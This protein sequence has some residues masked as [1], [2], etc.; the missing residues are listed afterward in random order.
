[1]LV[2]SILVTCK[3]V[4]TSFKEV[5]RGFFNSQP[6]V[7]AFWNSLQRQ[8]EWTRT[9]KVLLA[10]FVTL[11]YWNVSTMYYYFIVWILKNGVVSSWEEA[12]SL[13]VLSTHI[14]RHHL[15]SELIIRAFN[16]WSVFYWFEYKPTNTI[17]VYLFLVKIE[18]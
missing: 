3:E 17:M 8:S 4:I 9:Q 5:Q 11:D 2:R 14:F 7:I 6:Y 13:Q 12:D 18:T 16:K 15:F 10:I 1:M